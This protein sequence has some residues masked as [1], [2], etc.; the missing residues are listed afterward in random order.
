[1]AHS[2]EF[3]LTLSCP[4]REGIVDAVPGQ[5]YQAGSSIFDS[6]QFGDAESA[7]LARAVRW[8]VQHRVRPNCHKA[9]VFK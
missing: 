4:D 8:Q 2:R 7:V 5:L 6:Q 3:V 1:M 9:V